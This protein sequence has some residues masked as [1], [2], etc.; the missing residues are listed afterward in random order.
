MDQEDK[1]I[2]AS[3]INLDCR[4]YGKKFPDVDDLVMCLVTET[5]DAGAHT[6]LIEYNFKKGFIASSDISRKR[7]KQVKKVMRE[8]K[9]EILR[10]IRVDP[11]KGYIDLSK[12]NVIK[13]DEIA[14]FEEKYKKSKSVHGIMKTLAQKIQ[15]DVEVLYSEFGWDLYNHFDH[16]FDALKIALNNPNDVF[17][18]VKILDEHKKAL[19]EILSKKMIAQTV[20]IRADFK[21][22]CFTYEGID[23]IKFALAQGEK[24][25]T[26]EI[27]LK[28]KII[29]APVY[30]ISSVT[31]KQTEG[32]ALVNKALKAVENAIRSKEGNFLLDNQ[33][34]VYGDNAGKEIEEQIKKLKEKDEDASDIEEDHDEGIKV[35]IEGLEDNLCITKELEEKKVNDNESDD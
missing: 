21:L 27:P 5:D 31:V 25:S 9:E 13:Q 11:I 7:T 28:L 30:E 4:Y 26:Q 32:L 16:A 14:S 2:T 22:T 34:K 24:L 15:V 17:S 29:G 19:L 3:K 8:G 12:K 33:P 18:K 1:K 6:E 20:K 35:N 10:V 23:A